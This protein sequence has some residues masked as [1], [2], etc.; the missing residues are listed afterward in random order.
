MYPALWIALVVKSVDFG[1]K[2][3]RL[4]WVQHSKYFSHMEKTISSKLLQ[5]RDKTKCSNSLDLCAHHV[6]YDIFSP[7]RNPGLLERSEIVALFNTLNRLSESLQA[8]KKFRQL[9]HE[10]THHHEVKYQFLSLFSSLECFLL[11][12]Y[13]FS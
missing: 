12:T 6:K 8:I 1:V 3:K 2:S 5:D 9:Y 10:R 11:I 13:K 7:K 4:D